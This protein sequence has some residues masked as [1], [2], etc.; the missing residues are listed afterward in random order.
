MLIMVLFVDLFHLDQ[1]HR[2]IVRLRFI[3]Q[4]LTMW[5]ADQR[6]AEGRLPWCLV[7]IFEM[8]DNRKSLGMTRLGIRCHGNFTTLILV[9]LLLLDVDDRNDERDRAY[10][11]L[12]FR[13]VHW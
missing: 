3:D 13:V 8:L 10:R 2:T 11:W 9:N 4:R 1:R 6:A 7:G 5:A 12:V